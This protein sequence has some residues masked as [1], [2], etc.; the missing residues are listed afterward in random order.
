ML[1]V[2]RVC[3]EKVVG[4]AEMRKKKGKITVPKRGVMPTRKAVAK[5]AEKQRRGMAATREYGKKRSI[6]DASLSAKPV[7]KGSLSKT[8]EAQRRGMAT[9]R[10]KQ[11]K[12]RLTAEQ[13]RKVTQRDKE[14]IQDWM[15]EQRKKFGFNG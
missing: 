9:T 15:L 5:K 11:Q 14:A 8:A 13:R 10:A 12:G 1:C 3:L 7:K 4:V 2:L 6:M